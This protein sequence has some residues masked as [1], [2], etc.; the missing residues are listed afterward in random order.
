ME[1]RTVT[2]RLVICSR[3]FSKRR[4]TLDRAVVDALEDAERALHRAGFLPTELRAEV[5][6]EEK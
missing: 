2:L 3:D 5:M 1:A 4:A 6:R